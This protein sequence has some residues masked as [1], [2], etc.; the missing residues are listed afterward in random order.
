VMSAAAR[1]TGFIDG[2][3]RSAKGPITLTLA[4]G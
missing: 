1:G 3:P 4:R 2:A